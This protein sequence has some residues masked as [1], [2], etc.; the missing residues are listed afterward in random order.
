SDQSMLLGEVRDFRKNVSLETLKG[1][2]RRHE[3]V[4]MLQL[5][6]R[7][8][9]TLG[10]RLRLWMS[11]PNY[12]DLEGVVLLERESGEWMDIGLIKL[13]RTLTAADAPSVTDF[14]W[15]DHE[16]LHRRDRPWVPWPE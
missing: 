3:I 1:E 12:D 14:P 13:S 16:I 8:S 2:R 11:P 9:L 4:Q 10:S 7:Q 15:Q 5:P 6:R